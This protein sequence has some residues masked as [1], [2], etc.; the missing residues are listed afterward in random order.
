MITIHTYTSTWDAAMTVKPGIR[1]GTLVRIHQNPDAREVDSFRAH[2][3][4][5]GMHDDEFIRAEGKYAVSMI[6][7]GKSQAEIDQA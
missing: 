1:A 5:I 4:K 6:N 7:H 3:K 2:L